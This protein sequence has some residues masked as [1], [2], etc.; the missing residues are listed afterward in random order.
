MRNILGIIFGVVVAG[1]VLAG[2]VWLL[3]WLFVVAAVVAVAGIVWRAV[4]QER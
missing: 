4:T 1:F 3:W 2:I